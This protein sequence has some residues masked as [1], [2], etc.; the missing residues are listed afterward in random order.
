MVIVFVDKKTEI[1]QEIAD[2]AYDAIMFLDKKVEFWRQEN[3]A[4][5]K[6]KA[7]RLP[8]IAA[9]RARANQ[10]VTDAMTQIDESK[11]PMP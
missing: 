7:D 9:E 4:P 11:S 8:T 6:R 5:R 2:E 10:W 3:P 1:G